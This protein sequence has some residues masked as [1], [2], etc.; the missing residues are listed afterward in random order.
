MAETK[1]AYT[2]VGPG[3]PPLYGARAKVLIL[4]SFPG[5]HPAAGPKNGVSAG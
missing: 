2:H 1:A 5:G 3:L 4:G